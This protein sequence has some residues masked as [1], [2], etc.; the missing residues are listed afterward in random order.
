V[1]NRAD[2]IVKMLKE[3]AKKLDDEELFDDWKENVISVLHYHYSEK[4]AIAK[5]VYGEEIINRGI[6]T[7][8]EL[9]RIYDNEK[10]K[11]K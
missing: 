7:R 11:T 5:D 3:R 1:E 9:N 8:E 10:R 6:K 2:E 4:E